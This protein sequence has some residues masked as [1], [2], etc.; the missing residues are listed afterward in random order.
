ML[1]H[2][3]QDRLLL[4]QALGDSLVSAAGAVHTPGLKP[5][6]KGGGILGGIGNTILGG[7]RGA[8][9]PGLG[10]SSAPTPRPTPAPAPAAPQPAAQSTAGS[11]ITRSLGSQFK[12]DPRSYMQQ[13]NRSGPLGGLMAA[14]GLIHAD[15]LKTIFGDG[16][17]TA[18]G[19]GWGDSVQEAAK[20][21]AGGAALG[22]I[23]GVSKLLGKIPGGGAVGG[24]LG[25]GGKVLPAVSGAL[26]V[27]WAP[28]QAI[29]DAVNGDWDAAKSR[30]HD[31]N[32]NREMGDSSRSYLGRAWEA[33][34]PSN[35]Y[36]NAVGVN[37]A[38]TDP[39]F[40]KGLG[41]NLGLLNDNNGA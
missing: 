6:A 18:G 20:G 19:P 17:D 36:R 22:A 10:R 26:N 14:G 30:F 35:F 23:P 9:T 4:K 33:A 3:P 2:N 13:A 29:G 16:T 32:Y 12:A 5:P 37:S 24:L 40:W 41:I 1:L 31:E 34:A 21:W 15:S 38:V 25:V 39:T 11:D 27:G 7:A 28:A 8:A